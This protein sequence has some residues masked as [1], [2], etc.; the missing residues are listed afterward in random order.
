M[1]FATN[2]IA[3]RKAKLQRSVVAERNCSVSTQKAIK[4]TLINCKEGK[5]QPKKISLILISLLLAF[6]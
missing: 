4:S 5:Y 3:L 2:T 6:K 1:A